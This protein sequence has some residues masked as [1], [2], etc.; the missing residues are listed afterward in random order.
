[1]IQ[2]EYLARTFEADKDHDVVVQYLQDNYPDV[3][4]KQ[5]PQY[6]ALAL[7][8]WLSEWGRHG[9]ELVSC[10]LADKLG[11]K[12]D[13]GYAY[14]VVYTWRRTYVCIFKRPKPETG[15]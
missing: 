12:G 9:W 4:W 13:V 6:D 1:V 3:S 5:L 7:E 14:P 11:N 8:A 2:W 10:E 15:Q